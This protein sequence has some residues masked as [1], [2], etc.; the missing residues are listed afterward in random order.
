MLLVHLEYPKGLLR[1]YS[2]QRVLNAQIYQTLHRTT[3]SV[4]TEYTEVLRT[5]VQLSSHDI[6]VTIRRRSHDPWIQ[7]GIVQLSHRLPS[8]LLRVEVVHL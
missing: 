7:T 4:K 3:H 5:S 6:Q 8:Q 1:S 2:V